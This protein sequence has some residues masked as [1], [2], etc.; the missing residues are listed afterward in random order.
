MKVLETDRLIIR[1]L[2]LNDSDFIIELL[3]DPAFLK[4]IGD[5]KVRNVQDAHKYILDGPVAS[6]E[7]N[8]FGLY[9]VV[10][11]ES[12]LPIGICGLIKRDNLENVD[13]GFAFLPAYRGKGYASESG[14]AVL[15]FG[16]SK[17]GLKK[18]V[19]VTIPEN[20]G[21]IAV[22]EK[23]GMNFEK[24]VRMDENEPEIRL[25]SIEFNK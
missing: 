16:R 11:K 21:S 7:K 19:G 20:A 17:F 10:L 3:N 6:Y 18:I 9:L 25:Y 4:N 22:L 12:A 15:E 14:S 5:K 23:L 13:L 1:Q 24:M 8:G 2:T